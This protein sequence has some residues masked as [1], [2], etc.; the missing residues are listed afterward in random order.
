MSPKIVRHRAEGRSY[1]QI[2]VLTKV[3]PRRAARI[4]QG[5]ML[6]LIRWLDQA[7]FLGNILGGYVR[8]VF[9]G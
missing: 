4:E 1:R 6:K 9:Q 7:V 3:A 5:A 8:R 2:E